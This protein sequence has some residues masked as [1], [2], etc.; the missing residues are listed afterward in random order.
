MDYRI[1]LSDLFLSDLKEIVAYLSIQA[2]R[3]L[4]SRVGNELLDRTEAIGLSPW[5]G[6][7]VKQRPGTRKAI[8]YSYLIYYEVD[9][10]SHAV[11]ILRAW[12][13]ARDPKTLRME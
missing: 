7:P 11:N 5:L 3:D 4:A 1:V 10:T 8:F 13:G 2:S 6:S 12:H 9:E